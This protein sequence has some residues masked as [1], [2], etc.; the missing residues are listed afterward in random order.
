MLFLSEGRAEEA[1][2]P[3]KIGSVLWNIGEHRTAQGKTT[4]RQLNKGRLWFHQER[5]KDYVRWK[6]SK[7]LVDYR[8]NRDDN[9]TIN[10]VAPDRIMVGL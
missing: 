8:M 2:E 9:T 6:W 5:I 4:F 7:R 10:I 3:S 1:W